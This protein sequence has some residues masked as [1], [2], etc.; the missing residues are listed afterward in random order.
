MRLKPCKSLITEINNLTENF[1]PK[2]NVKSSKWLFVDHYKPPCQ[3]EELFISNLSKSINVFSGKY[4]I[5]LLISDF[6]LTAIENKRLEELLDIF[7]LK[8]LILSLTYFQPKNCAL[9]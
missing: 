9:I 4:G 8:S 1:F 3:N 6:N 5:I 2:T 7:N